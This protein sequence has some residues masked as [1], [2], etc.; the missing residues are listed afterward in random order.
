MQ[1]MAANHDN[2]TRAHEAL[3]LQSDAL[4]RQRAEE[5]TSSEDRLSRML[6]TQKFDLLDLKVMQPEMFKGRR[7]DAFKP[8][9]WKL[10][11]YCNANRHGFRKAV[12]GAEPQAQK[13]TDLLG[14]N[15]DHAIMADAKLHV[16]L[17]MMLGKDARILV[18]IP[19]LDS[20]GFEA[21]RFLGKRYNP[22]GGQYAFDAIMA[23]MS[24]TAD[25]DITQLPWAIS[26]FERGV[27]VYER[28]AGRT[29]FEELKNDITK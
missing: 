14:M 25:K 7:L 22:S 20:R 6:F 11:A 24:L 12:D 19:D 13:I 5:I 16:F 29:F 21:W 9:A 15:W 8:W 2:L 3:R 28:R 1:M 23:L 4:F 18:E 27:K 17:L 10:K 26:R